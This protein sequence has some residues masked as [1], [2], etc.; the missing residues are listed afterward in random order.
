MTEE[1]KLKSGWTKTEVR[2]DNAEWKQCDIIEN[3]RELQISNK[4]SVPILNESSNPSANAERQDYNH[5]EAFRHL[6]TVDTE[7]SVC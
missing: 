4:P 2:V 5:S 1:G 3:N 7:D 6:E